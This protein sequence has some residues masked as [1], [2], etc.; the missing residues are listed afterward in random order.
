MMKL[1][2]ESELRSLLMDS[3]LLRR[4]DIMGVDN[5]VYYEDVLFN[6]PKCEGTLG[7]LGRI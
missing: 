5:W 4:L 6:N 2:D 7:G 3:E 1:I